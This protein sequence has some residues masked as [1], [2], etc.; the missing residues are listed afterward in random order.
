MSV[1]NCYDLQ[2][3]APWLLTGGCVSYC[4]AHFQGGS[5][6]DHSNELIV[7]NGQLLVKIGKTT[8]RCLYVDV[9][10]TDNGE[11]V[12]G[13]GGGWPPKGYQNLDPPSQADQPPVGT[14]R[15]GGRAQIGEG[16]PRDGQQKPNHTHGPARTSNRE[17]RSQSD[18]EID[19]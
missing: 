19:K 18:M 4:H 10:V 3:H 16:D 12:P 6:L 14:P 8:M 15:F 11:T 1:Q 7:F 17:R 13:T 5:C 9:I 2:Q